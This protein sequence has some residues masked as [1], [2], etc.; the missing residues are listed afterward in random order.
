MRKLFTILAAVLLTATVWA[1]SPE[2]MSYQA[3]IRNSSDVLVTSTQIGIE[4]NI[5]QGSPTGT[6]VYTETQ[7]PTTNA[8]GL[9]SIEIG[10]AGF[11]SINW[12]G[13]EYYIETKTA[14]VPPLTTYTIT[15]TSQLLS[16]PYALSAKKAETADY[17]SLTNLPTLFDGQYSSLSGTP[18]LATV[19]T[20]GNYNDLSNLPALFDG[21]YNNLTNLPTLFSGAYPDLTGKPTLWDSTWASIKNKPTLFDSDYNSLSNLPTL[22]DGQYSSL[23]GAPTLATVAT[24]GSYADLT[25]QPTIPAAADGSETKITAGTNITLTGAGTTVSPYV[26]N[27]AVSMTQ[28]QRDALTPVEGLIVYNNS[29][30]QP[31]YYNGTEW[32]N[33]D[34]TSAMTFALGVSYQ[35]GIVAYILQ[36][37]DPGYVAGQTHGLIAAPS[38]QSTGIQWY[39][40]SLTTTGAIATAIGTGNANTNTIVSIQGTGSYAAQLC[41]D[42]VLGGY[43]DWYLPSKDELNQ[44]YLNRVAIGGFTTNSYWSSSESGQNASYMLLFVNGIQTNQGKGITLSVRAVRAF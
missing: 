34:G 2:K 20:T 27:T 1:Q 13:D 3:V 29:T 35:G 18:T 22:F 16:V 32:M 21:N 28:V 11:S 4:I 40:G 10:G 17:N 7:T 38:D 42:L 43:S 33:Y 26:I 24:S 9:V 41:A 36:P 8:N 37:G 39:N 44:L 6:V 23:S 15:C 12:A 25:N 31:N 14:I 30:H 5:R 19:A